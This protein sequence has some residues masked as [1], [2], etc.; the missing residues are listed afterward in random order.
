MSDKR[1]VVETFAPLTVS[2]PELMAASEVGV[3]ADISADA[4]PVRFRSEFVLNERRYDEGKRPLTT[5]GGFAASRRTWSA[6]GLLAYRLPWG[7]LEPYLYF[8]YNRDPTLGSMEPRT[9]DFAKSSPCRPLDST[10]ILPPR[11]SSRSSMRTIYSQ[12]SMIWVGIFLGQTSTFSALASWCRS[13]GRLSA[14]R[15]PH[16][17]GVLSTLLEGR[18]AIAAPE[19]RA[20]IVHLSNTASLSPAEIAAIG[21][22]AHGDL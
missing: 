14:L 4:G 21:L 15:S 6:Y 5:S 19:E 3:G 1:V 20:V 12:M 13:D 7:G 18:L 10:F 17:P 8:E 11:L 16:V 2:R 9:G 22:S